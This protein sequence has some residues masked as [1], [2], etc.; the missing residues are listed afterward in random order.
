MEQITK[1]VY[2][3]TKIRGCNP[4]MIFTSKGAVF[5][6]TAQWISTLLEMR[7]FA[8]SRGTIPYLINTEGHIDHIFG[9]H[10]FANE[11]LV[12]G[13]E[14]LNDLFWTVAGE[15]DC[16]DYS[17]DVIRR[18]DPK[19]LDLMPSRD[20][21]IVNRPQITFRDHLTLQLG[22]TTFEMY[23]TPGHSTSQLCVYVPQEGV[24]FT[25]DTIFSGCQTWLHSAEIDP[26]LTTLDFLETLD[27]KWLV[28]GHGPVVGMEYIATQ[29]AIIYEWIS[30]VANGVQRG[31]SC[32][33]CQKNI[34]FASK[35]PVDIGQDE[36]MDYIQR[37][38]VAK[39]YSYLTRSKGVKA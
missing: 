22:E 4:G 17:V 24:V 23:H 10:W 39:C 38:N 14:K 37:T 36:M 5:I 34:N 18:Q 25:G 1:N 19:M 11:T 7:Q 29:R 27:A 2:V 32:E 26:L 13:H 28:P 31:W 12:V 6:D 21:Y 16:Y 20:E 35:S 33:E 15:M 8:L 9:N 30:A 3:E